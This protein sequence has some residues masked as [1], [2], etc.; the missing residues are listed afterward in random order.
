MLE[1]S[2]HFEGR[3][4][5]AQILS[6]EELV[7]LKGEHWTRKEYFP[8][9]QHESQEVFDFSFIQEGAHLKTSYFVG[10]SWLVPGKV[11]FRVRPKLD[12]SEV[13]IDYFQMLKVALDEPQVEGHLSNLIKIDFSQEPM[14][15]SAR[16]E[17]LTLFLVVQFV[18]LLEDLLRRGLLRSFHQEVNKYKNKIKGKIL[19]SP[20]VSKCKDGLPL[21]K[22]FICAHQNLD[23]NVF[24]NQLL[25]TA[26]LAS[27]RLLDG[28]RDFYQQDPSL[29]RKT[30]LI[31]KKLQTIRPLERG[32]ALNRVKLSPFFKKYREPVRLAQL[33]L[34][35]EGLSKSKDAVPTV[36][37]PLY[38]INM[39][40][41]FELYVLSKLKNSIRE[42]KIDYHLRFRFKEPDFLIRDSELSLGT[43]IADAKYK[44]RYA[45]RESALWEDGK[46]L[47]GYSRYLPIRKYLKFESHLNI[48]CVILYSDQG[49]E[50]DFNFDDL[51]ADYLFEDLYKIGIKLPQ[52]PIVQK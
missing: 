21:A 25:K 32:E 34:R 12:N 20:S 50:E 28:N 47:A 36:R 14:V 13:E 4:D 29:R 10:M 15:I 24:V 8:G 37:V 27:Q 19:L 5:L 43:F 30:T 48:P 23:E 38:W 49:K 18:S 39:T 16:E 17:G 31:S 1:F 9:N 46:Q 33:I 11:P 6:E 2:E 44:P 45:T 35:L 7:K 51:E 40:K 52:K 22:E 41:L 42:G 26:F 3:V